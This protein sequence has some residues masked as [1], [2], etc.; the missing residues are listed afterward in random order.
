MSDTDPH[1]K[2]TTVGNLRLSYYHPDHRVGRM[3][4]R[5]YNLYLEYR[6]FQ[7]D[8]GDGPNREKGPYAEL[9]AGTA[10]AV[11]RPGNPDIPASAG[12][13]VLRLAAAASSYMNRQIVFETSPRDEFRWKPPAE[14]AAE[15]TGN[16][17]D[18]ATLKVEL[19]KDLGVPDER[20]V[21][22]VGRMPNGAGHAFP[23]VLGED[24]KLYALD[25]GTRSAFRPL[26]AHLKATGFLPDSAFHKGNQMT[27][28]G[29]TTDAPR[30]DSQPKISGIQQLQRLVAEAPATPDSDP[31]TSPSPPR[32]LPT[33]PRLA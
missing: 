18:Y 33:T 8:V 9:L 30:N 22:L 32:V 11:R 26:D 16:C 13:P 28:D 7:D 20:I 12:D 4:A 1:P 31:S 25:N 10:E 23:A 2:D 27:F 5:S 14:T 24:G 6:R 3:P 21:L 29:F 19:L 15:K 17:K